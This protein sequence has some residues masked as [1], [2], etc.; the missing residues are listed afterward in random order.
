VV[1]SVYFPDG[2]IAGHQTQLYLVLPI[3][4]SGCTMASRMTPSICTTRERRFRIRA[5]FKELIN[6]NVNT[7]QEMTVERKKP[8]VV[9]RRTSHKIN[10]GNRLRE[11]HAIGNVALAC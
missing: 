10:Q 11:R 9:L 1:S 8:H 7:L 4:F 5:I 2:A 6:Q 3:E